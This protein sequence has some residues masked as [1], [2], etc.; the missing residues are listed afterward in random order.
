MIRVQF[1]HQIFRLQETGGISRYFVELA[2]AFIENP[3]IGI[4]PVF[5]FKYTLNKHLYDAFPDM[6]FRLVESF[7]G[8]TLL[9]AMAFLP[10][11]LASRVDC[12][13]YTFYLPLLSRKRPA[14][15]TVST[16][17][18]MIPELL[19]AKPGLR[20]PH[21]N[22]IWYLQESSAV[23]SV[24]KSSAADFLKIVKQARQD[25]KIVPHGTGLARIPIETKSGDSGCLLFVGKRSG[26]K[27]G[28]LAVKALSELNNS[29]LELIFVGGGS[30]SRQETE[31]IENL[32]LKNQVSH[33]SPTDEEL[34][35][36][37]VNAKAFISPSRFEGF[38]LPI[39]EASLF[40]LPLVISKIPPYEELLGSL[41][42]YF[43]V[44]SA[45]QLAKQVLNVQQNP[46]KAEEVASG[47]KKI[48][49]SYTWEK[50]ARLT[51]QVYQGVVLQT[52]TEP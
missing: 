47:C 28:M 41:A 20:N 46:A 14:V 38:G 48:A 52:K 51:S 40:K 29:D 27:D 39:L 22:K 16:L 36:L 1:D 8:K 34:V 21:F 9:K 31:L 7:L 42:F 17:H 15:P 12:L 37:Y 26:Y 45:E 24:S 13:H 5:N 18:D 50:C 30:F 44:G 49:E 43:E 33:V 25:L 3:D 10:N 2:R 11:K 6:G 4:E 23:I 35:E 19:G 32:G